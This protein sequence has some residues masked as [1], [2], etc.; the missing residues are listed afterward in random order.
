MLDGLFKSVSEGTIDLDEMMGSAA[1][2]GKSKGVDD[3]HLAM[4]W[5]IDHKM[6]EKTLD[7][8]NQNSQRTDD[9]KLSRHLYAA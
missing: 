2:A 5:R 4:I 1:H 8:T 7:I 3:A 6:A 9:T